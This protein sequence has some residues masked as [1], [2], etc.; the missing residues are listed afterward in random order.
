M[1][2]KKIQVPLIIV[3]FGPP[4]IGKGTFAHNC[5]KSFGWRH[6]STGNLCR[7]RLEKGD[8]VSKELLSVINSGN[9]INDDLMLAILSPFLD[10]VVNVVKSECESVKNVEVDNVKDSCNFLR[11]Y[12]ATKTAFL[13][14]GFPRNDQQISLLKRFLENNNISVD[15]CLFV[16]FQASDEVVLDRLSSRIVCSNKSCEVSYSKKNYEN[17]HCN[18][19]QARLM[20]RV[21]DDDAIARDRLALYRKNSDNMKMLLSKKNFPS[22][23]LNAEQSEEDII[24]NFCEQF[25]INN[26]GVHGN[27]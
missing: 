12:F 26:D 20:R 24:N 7:A 27:Y 5:L 8:A 2:N 21:D 23:S 16:F 9:L 15:R 19:C 14:D 18:S 1:M 11:D 17:D 4:G 3:P 25:L 10:T 22:F 13:L 6:I